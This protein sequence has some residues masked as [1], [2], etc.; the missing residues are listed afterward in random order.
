M[1]S[2]DQGIT[3][4]VGLPIRNDNGICISM[5][6]LQPQQVRHLYSKKYLHEDE[7]PY[8]VSKENSVKLTINEVNMAIAICYELS[9]PEHSENAFQQGTEIYLASVAKSASGV[10]RAVESLTEIARKYSM[11]VVMSNNVGPSDNFVGGGKSSVRNSKGQLLGQLNDS[12][13][14]ILVI[15]TLTEVVVAAKTDDW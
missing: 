15:D 4:G 3:I 7:E 13:E 14:G 9:V 11:T 1:I 10:E 5:I 6:L 12:Q 8:F 2:D